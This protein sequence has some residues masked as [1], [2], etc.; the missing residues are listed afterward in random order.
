LMVSWDSVGPVV[1]EKKSKKRCLEG[2]KRFNVKCSGMNQEMRFLSGGNQQKVLL[3]RWLISDPDIVILD[4][5]TRGID[6]GAK[7]EIYKEIRDISAKGKAVLMVS[8]ELPE[9]LGVCDRIVVMHEGTLMAI[10]DRDEA[11]QEKIMHYASGLKTN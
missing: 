4:E 9:I 3:E 11:D 8:S 10:L 6:V 5:P 7:S 1:N 2:I